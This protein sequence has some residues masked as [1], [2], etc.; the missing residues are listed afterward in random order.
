MVRGKLAAYCTLIWRDLGS[1]FATAPGTLS[2]R[3][4]FSHDAVMWSGLA[5]LGSWND[6]ENDEYDRSRHLRT[7]PLPS[8]PFSSPV[9]SLLLCLW[10]GCGLSAMQCEYQCYE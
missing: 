5:P 9:S 3:T 7:T 1:S 10:D 4:P 2:E 8:S 6:R